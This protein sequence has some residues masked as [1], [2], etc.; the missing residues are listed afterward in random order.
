MA[1]DDRIDITDTNQSAFTWACRKYESE[2]YIFAEDYDK[3]KI[4]EKILKTHRIKDS[5][6]KVINKFCFY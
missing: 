1:S 2:K 6:E 5:I 4:K 3:Q